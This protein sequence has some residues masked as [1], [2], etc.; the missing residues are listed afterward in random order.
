MILYPA[1][2]SVSAKLLPYFC[3]AYDFRTLSQIY[4]LKGGVFVGSSRGYGLKY[5]T[6]GGKYG[7]FPL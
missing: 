3:V 7:T 1:V 4:S 6:I 5:L 2:L